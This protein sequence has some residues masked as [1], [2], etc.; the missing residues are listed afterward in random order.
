VFV[1]QQYRVEPPPELPRKYSVAVGNARTKE[2][3]LIEGATLADEKEDSIRGELSR[4]HHKASPLIA[5]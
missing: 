3:L 5:P 4:K 2:G 1:Y